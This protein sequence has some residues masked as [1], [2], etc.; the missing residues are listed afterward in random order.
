MKAP[1]SRWRVSESIPARTCRS[2]SGTYGAS[3]HAVSKKQGRDYTCIGC[4]GID[5]DDEV[6]ILPDVRWARMET[7]QTVE[8]LLH[9]F[10]QHEPFAWYMESELISKS[11]GPFLRARMKSEKLYTMLDPITPSVDIETRAR[12]IQGMMSLGVVHFPKW[13]PWY[14]RARQQI[15]TFPSSSNDDFRWRGWPRSG[16]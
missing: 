1:I 9:Q 5:E 16:C 3:D 12:S 13:A 4:I 15:L 11:F 8:E 10:R 2:A 6:W 7:D 14:S